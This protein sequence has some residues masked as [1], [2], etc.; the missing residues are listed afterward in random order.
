M[1]KIVFY[2][3]AIKDLD[4]ISS[5]IALDNPL[6]AKLVLRDIF[7]SI[8]YLENFPLLGKFRKEKLRELVVKHKYRVFYEVDK[9]LI[10]VIAIFKHKNF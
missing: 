1:H 5:F 2:K 7:N 3:S 10:T 6:Q 9:S 8:K 4:E